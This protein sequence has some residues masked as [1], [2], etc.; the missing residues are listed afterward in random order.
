VFVSKIKVVEETTVRFDIDFASFVRELG[1]S[2]W[3]EVDKIDP[4]EGNFNT[5][6]IFL[7]EKGVPNDW[8]GCTVDAA[9][10]EMGVYEALPESYSVFCSGR[11]GWCVDSD[12]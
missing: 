2:E 4:R 1:N 10:S 12:C 9:S 8:G 5:M 7:S 6:T 3:L 11:G